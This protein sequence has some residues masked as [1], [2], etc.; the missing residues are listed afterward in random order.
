M[1]SFSLTLPHSQS[2]SLP[3]SLLSLYLYLSFSPPLFSLYIFL[4]YLYLYI[5]L[6]PISSLSIYL[7]IY[8]YISPISNSISI[9]IPTSLSNLVQGQG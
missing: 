9:S 1:Y 7:S 2:L 4:I 6:S 8:L 5:Y 3:P